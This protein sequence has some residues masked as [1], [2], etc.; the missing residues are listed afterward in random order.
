MRKA[1]YFVNDLYHERFYL[2]AGF[3]QKQVNE[4]LKKLKIADGMDITGAAGVTTYFQGGIVIWLVA[5][6]KSP[7][8]VAS[9]VHECVHASN[10]ILGTRGVGA[11]HDNDEAQCYLTE[12]IFRNCYRCLK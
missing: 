12:W 11:C 1:F 4:S 3:N 5:N 2:L 6:D 7:E 8:N 10:M 9:L